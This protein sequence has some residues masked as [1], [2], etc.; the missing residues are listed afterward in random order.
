MYINPVM[1]T[2]F[3]GSRRTC[4][5]RLRHVW[6]AEVAIMNITCFVVITYFSLTTAERLEICPVGVNVGHMPN[7]EEV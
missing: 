4:L 3:C 2:Q 5:S 7:R 6:L 1:R